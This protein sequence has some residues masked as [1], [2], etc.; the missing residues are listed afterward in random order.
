MAKV[1]KAMPETNGQSG[2]TAS[3][4][5]IEVYGARVHNLK[6]IDISIPKE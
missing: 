1:K 6:N 5:A 4:D 2:S 3:H